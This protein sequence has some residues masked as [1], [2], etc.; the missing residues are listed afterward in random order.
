MPPIAS[1][2]CAPPPRR[3][4]AAERAAA[5]RGEV[6]EAK[7]KRDELE[8]LEAEQVALK[9]REAAL[10]AADEADRLEEA[11]VRAKERRKGA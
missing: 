3:K 1:N 9:R 2:C 6:I 10:T 7:S 11:A 8:A 4:R 5:Q